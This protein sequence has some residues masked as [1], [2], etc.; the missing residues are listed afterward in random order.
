LPIALALGW[1][2]RVAGVAAACDFGSPAAWTFEPLDHDVFP[3][4]RVARQAGISGGA[5]PAVYN[6][7]NEELVDAF[8]AGDTSFTSIVDTVRQVLDQSDQWSADPASVEDVLAAED[9]ARARA[10]ELAGLPA[11]SGR[12]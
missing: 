6:A 1:P 12:N 2:R 10:R 4:V 8:A 7:A 5:R 9:W 3:A 11:V